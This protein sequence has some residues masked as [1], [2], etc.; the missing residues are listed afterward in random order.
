MVGMLLDR[1]GDAAPFVR[2]ANDQAAQTIMANL[3]SSGEEL[4]VSSSV[5]SATPPHSQ[6]PDTNAKQTFYFQRFD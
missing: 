1:F 3:S 2:D 4:R 6:M 5:A